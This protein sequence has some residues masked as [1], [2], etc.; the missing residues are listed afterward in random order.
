LLS[1][2]PA[3]VLGI[4]QRLLFNEGEADFHFFC[5]LLQVTYRRKHIEANTGIGV[6]F[7]TC[8]VYIGFV[9]RICVKYTLFMREVLLQVP[10]ICVNLYPPYA[11]KIASLHRQFGKHL[12]SDMAHNPSAPAQTGAAERLAG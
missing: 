8:I 7:R 10:R 3:E 9:P 1:N 5:G 4:W 6:C 2:L 12:G 11:W